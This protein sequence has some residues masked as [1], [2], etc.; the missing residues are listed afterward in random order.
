MFLSGSLQILKDSP[1]WKIIEALVKINYSLQIQTTLLFSLNQK[2]EVGD[3][4][5]IIER[6]EDQEMHGFPLQVK[7]KLLDFQKLETKY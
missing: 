1:I 2:E 5:I 7:R 4:Q 6:K 3:A